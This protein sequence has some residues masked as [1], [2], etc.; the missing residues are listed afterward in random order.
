MAV[1]S[2]DDERKPERNLVGTLLLSLAAIALFAAAYRFGSHGITEDD[3]FCI[4][5]SSVA[6]GVGALLLWLAFRQHRPKRD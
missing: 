1:G 5:L 4:G 3:N 6:L 2:M